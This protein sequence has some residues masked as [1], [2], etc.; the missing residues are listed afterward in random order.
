MAS[1]LNARLARLE[2]TGN[3][4]SDAQVGNV[5]S[6]LGRLEEA[7]GKPLA[8]ALHDGSCPRGWQALPPLRDPG[9]VPEIDSVI[10]FSAATGAARAR[11]PLCPLCSGPDAG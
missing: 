9:D 3:R 1:R 7:T 10:W 4:P 5:L 11:P 6:L 2:R 8:V